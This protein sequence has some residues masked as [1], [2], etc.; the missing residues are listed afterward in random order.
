MTTR[1]TNAELRRLARTY[2]ADLLRLPHASEEGAATYVLRL[3][4]HGPGVLLLAGTHSNE[5][6][7]PSVLLS[8][9]ERLCL[10]IRDDTDIAFGKKS[11]TKDDVS[12]IVG[13]LNILLL[14]LV[15]P[16]GADWQEQ[17]VKLW[18]RNRALN[19]D[20]PCRP[21][22]DCRG[23]DINRN[24]NFLWHCGLNASADAWSSKY[25]GPAPASEPETRN[26]VWLLDQEE[27]EIGF[28]LDLHALD[29][30]VNG[31]VLYPWGDAPN[32]TSDPKQSFK[33]KP[34][35]ADV[36]GGKYR[37]YLPIADHTWFKETSKAV[38]A[39]CSDAV[40]YTAK[41]SYELY[42]TTGTACD[43]AYSRH[44]ANVS[45]RPVLPILIECASPFYPSPDQERRVIDEVSAGIFEFLL[46]CA[47]DVARTRRAAGRAQAGPARRNAAQPS[48][49]SS[50]E[51][52][53]ASARSRSASAARPSRLRS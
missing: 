21:E 1:E 41:Q 8:F 43:Y 42:P 33:N 37:E 6:V 11:Y 26:V 46:R 40:T 50:A 3:N 45:K 44:I 53:A 25:K 36:S 4:D 19:W 22:Y 23:V 20:A 14:P 15:N 29:R 18:R 7:T 52:R 47:K 2:V 24:F 51:A 28:L 30:P 13:A 34:K 39:A 17:T 32:Q 48:R 12:T 49:P 38:A 27:L 16:D 5:T 10:A 31:L 35:C 9:A